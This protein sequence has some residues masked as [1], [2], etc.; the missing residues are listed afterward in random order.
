MYS[1]AWSPDG[2]RLAAGAGNA[3]TITN[4]ADG[5]TTTL[6]NRVWGTYVFAWSPG[7]TRLAVVTAESADLWDP[8]AAVAA[9]GLPIVPHSAR[10]A[11]WS[12]DGKLIAIAD[13]AS[14]RLCNAADGAEVAELERSGKTEFIHPVTWS[15]DGTMLATEDH[16]VVRLWRFTVGRWRGRAKWRVVQTLA[17]HTGL[18]RAHAWS[19][20]GTHLASTGYDGTLRLWDPA[21]GT[22]AACIATGHRGGGHSVGWS[23]DGRHLATG[24]DTGLVIVWDRN[25]REVTSLVLQPSLCLAW[26]APLLAVGQPGGPA[27]LELRDPADL[28]P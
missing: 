6:S 28:D 4:H 22:A 15:P 14:L 9:V 16:D 5:T 2:T 11:A 26:G 25:G 3:I 12:P 21:S 24:D 23:P 20:D 7:G 17:G 10:A 27:I 13:R 8:I 19:P 18:I 1:L